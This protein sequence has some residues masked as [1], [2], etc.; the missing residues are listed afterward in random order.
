[1]TRPATGAHEVRWCFHTTAM[2]T[3]Y[4]RTRD[5]LIRI[6]GLR[7][8]EDSRIEE[9]AIG[10]RGGMAWMGDNILE[11]GEPIVEG[12]AADRFV[13]RFGSHMSTIAVQVSDIAATS[14]FLRE[15]GARLASEIDHGEHRIVFTHPADTAGI[16][17][18]WFGSEEPM[19]PRFGGLIPPM[20]A[21]PILDVEQMAFGGAV[22][23][24]PIA[25]AERLAAL[26]G[27]EVTFTDP[28]ARAGNPMA[29]VSMGDMTLAL[30]PVPSAADSESLWGY[31][32]TRPQTCNVGVRVPDLATAVS[33]LRDAGID[34]LR[35]DDRAAVIPPRATGGVTVVVVDELLPGDPRS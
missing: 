5:A 10:R 32:Y 16:V 15:Q 23:D 11:I 28:A 30:Y 4:E 29:G 14:A 9:P 25:A 34:V 24:D 35:A 1:M 19:D 8:L 27:R 22:V 7:V 21:D 18:E 26:F 20:H 12:G 33:A 13:R 6:G 2:V 17:I 31:T 3:D